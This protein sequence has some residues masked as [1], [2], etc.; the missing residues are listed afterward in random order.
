MKLEGVDFLYG[1]NY[2]KA[3]LVVCSVKNIFYLISVFNK[4]QSA[5]AALE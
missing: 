3:V 2:L 1:V 5:E 4:E